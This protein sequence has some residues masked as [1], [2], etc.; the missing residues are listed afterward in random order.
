M[1]GAPTLNKG[2]GFSLSGGQ[3]RSIQEGAVLVDV[4]VDELPDLV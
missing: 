1:N 3:R 4:L 2:G